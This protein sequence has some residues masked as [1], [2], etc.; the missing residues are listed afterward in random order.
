MKAVSNLRLQSI[1]SWVSNTQSSFRIKLVLFRTRKCSHQSPWSCSGIYSEHCCWRCRGNPWK[2]IDVVC[3]HIRKGFLF[4][5]GTL[6]HRQTWLYCGHLMSINLVQGLMK[7][8]VV[9]LGGVGVLRVNQFIEVWPGIVFKDENG[10]IKCT[11]IYLRVISLLAEQNEPQF[12]VPGGLIGVGRDS[13]VEHWVYV[14]RATGSCS[15]KGCCRIERCCSR[16]KPGE[17]STYLTCVH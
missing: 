13:Y 15:E 5:R 10:A 3:E 16:E 2:Y 4:Q 14:Y 9:L 8:R 12:A 1:S 6:F 11:P 17:A 7:S